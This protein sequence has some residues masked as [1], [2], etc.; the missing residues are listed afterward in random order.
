[1]AQIFVCEYV[2]YA[3]GNVM[4][5]LLLAFTG[6]AQ[7]QAYSEEVNQSCTIMSI[8]DYVKSW[9]QEQEPHRLTFNYTVFDE[10]YQWSVLSKLNAEEG[11]R[12]RNTEYDEAVRLVFNGSHHSLFPMIRFPTI[13]KRDSF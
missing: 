5:I 10:V 11:Y 2:S 8:R 6:L 9:L 13:G 3:P 12:Y 1:M 7:G 4:L